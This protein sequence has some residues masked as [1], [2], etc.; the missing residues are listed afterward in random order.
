[1]N[2]LPGMG[3]DPQKPLP[4]AVPLGHGLE[5]LEF[6]AV[7]LLPGGVTVTLH[8]TCSAPAAVPLPGPQLRPRCGAAWGLSSFVRSGN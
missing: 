8:T 7:S 4:C 2:K 1:M 5:I 3:M 6:L